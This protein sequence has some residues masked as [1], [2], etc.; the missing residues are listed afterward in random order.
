MDC[1][2]CHR[3][4]SGKYYLDFWQHPCCASHYEGGQVLSCS[5]CQSFTSVSEALRLPDGRQLCPD[6]QRLVVSTE[7]QVTRQKK[8]ILMR[9]NDVDITF[10]DRHLDSVPVS[11][12]TLRQMCEL[13]QADVSVSNKGMTLT[14]TTRRGLQTSYTHHVYVLD[15]LT[16]SDFT[17]TLAHEL[18]HVWQNEH[19]LSL[20]DP[21][22]EGLCNLAAW[23]VLHKLP[24]SLNDYYI[25]TLEENT[26]PVYGDGFRHVLARYRQVGWEG[27]L[28]EALDGRL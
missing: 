18:L 26:D 22:C 25:K 23:Y 4:L 24:S 6:C 14:T 12:V 10:A 9:L 15:H 8:L 16:R 21:S 17:L 20:P 2:I 11:I 13:R 3:P 1:Y 19:G 27:V 5:S 28:Q 7:E